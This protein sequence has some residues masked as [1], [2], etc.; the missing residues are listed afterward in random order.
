[1][2]VLCCLHWYNSIKILN[3]YY[4]SSLFAGDHVHAWIPIVSAQIWLRPATT[5]CINSVHPASPSAEFECWRD[6]KT[7]T[8]RISAS[9]S[10]YWQ[11]GQSSYFKF[12]PAGAQLIHKQPSSSTDLL[13]P[14]LMTLVPSSYCLNIEP[15]VL[16]TGTIPK[17]LKQMLKENYNSLQMKVDGEEWSFVVSI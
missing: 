7:P 11:R 6:Q 17:K 4:L 2:C 10:T 3:Y 1:M 8:P 15:Y 16:L 9:Y 14:S 13:F 5:N 12:G